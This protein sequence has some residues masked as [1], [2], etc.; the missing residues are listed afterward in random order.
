[1]LVQIFGVRL[2]NEV[3]LI[4]GIYMYRTVLL[5]VLNKCVIR[6]GMAR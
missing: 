6:I 1:M 3:L 2:F 5:N 4:K